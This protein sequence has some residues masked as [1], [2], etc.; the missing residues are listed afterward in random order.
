[1]NTIS[2]SELP[3]DLWEKIEP[4]LSRFERKRPGGRPPNPFRYLLEGMLYRLKTGCQWNMIP[5]QYGSKSA[6]HEHYQRW[7][8]A[9]VF[10]EILR[11][12]ASEFHG[13]SGFDFT[14]QAMDGSLIQAPVRKKKSFR[15]DGS[16]S[17][18]PG[19]DR[20]Q[21]SSA[22]GQKWPALGSGC[23]GGQCP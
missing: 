17:Y 1:M 23:R 19:T 22:C 7:V 5:K 3:E 12:I 18:G 20:Q 8:H 11:I 16:E 6:I 4:L 10:A 21:N 14:W 13:R 9:G 15:R 2:F